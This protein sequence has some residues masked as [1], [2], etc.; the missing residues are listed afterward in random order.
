MEIGSRRYTKGIAG[1]TIIFSRLHYLYNIQMP[2]KAI[3]SLYDGFYKDF[4]QERLTVN[5]GIVSICIQKV[6][7]L[8]RR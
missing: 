4:T 8:Q 3:K 2:Q 5:T 1:L 6:S 7:E